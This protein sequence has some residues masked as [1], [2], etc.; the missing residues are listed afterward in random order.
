MLKICAVL[1][2]LAFVL[3]GPIERIEAQRTLT[4]SRAST[5]KKHHG[6]RPAVA[7]SGE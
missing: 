3:K 4:Q 6:A 5:P 2:L 7:R 1:T